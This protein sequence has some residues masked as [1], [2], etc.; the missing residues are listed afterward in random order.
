MMP[1]PS[2]AEAVIATAAAA[3][4]EWRRTPR[5]ER[6]AVLH[7]AAELYSERA[8][9][10][11]RTMA[12]DMGKPVVQGRGEIANC[13]SILRYFAEHADALLQVETIEH[14]ADRSARIE[15]RPTGVVLG[16]MPWNYPHYQLIRLIAPSLLLGNGVLFKHARIC[17]ASARAVEEI[18]AE[19]GAPVGLV[20]D[21]RFDHAQTEAAIAHPAIA[22]VS[23]TGGDAA[24]AAIA[25]AAGAAVKKVV[26]EL[27][28][29]DPFIVFDASRA[30]E[31]A[32]LAADTRLA[33]AGQTCT[34]P[35]R[36]I[37]RSDLMPRFAERFAA[38]FLA[39][40]P[41]DPLREETALGPL[42]TASAADELR[43]IL[44]SAVERG[45]EVRGDRDELERTGR[46]FSPQIIIDPPHDHAVWTQELFG[47]VAILVPAAE[48][49]EAIALANDSVYGL[50]AT[51]YASD[52]ADGARFT[53]ELESGMVALNGP[54]GGNPAYPFGG[55]KRSGFGR[56]LGALGIREFANQQLVVEHS[57]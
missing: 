43:A 37:V 46:E 56:E 38:R 8:E 13:V 3:A 17:A 12:G 27:G 32:E 31:L 57:N 5:T 52:A 18:F 10:L 22:G 30:D 53:A 29:N 34:S 11:A 15:L 26:L 40:A 50:G 25:R 6:A 7:R 23:F 4:A 16:I 33:N 47:P 54:K 24:G 19:A 42:A 20:H 21:S 55:V 36:I 14:A 28:G 44:R 35:K 48:V 2:D 51:V 1:R 49:E 41:G 39:A 9:E 45:I